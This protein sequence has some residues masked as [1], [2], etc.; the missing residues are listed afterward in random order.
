MVSTGKQRYNEGVRR[1]HGFTLIELMIVVA[2]IG[3]LASI[4]I[5]NFLSFQCKSKQ[6]EAKA[7]LG[8]IFSVEK[9]FLSDNNTY[10]TDL[11]SLGWSPDGGPL[12]IYGFGDGVE[13]PPVNT[14]PGLPAYDPTRNDTGDP[15]VQ[16]ATPTWDVTRAKD[17][18]GTLFVGANLPPTL[19]S[20][21]AFLIG[22]VA[23][24]R[25]DAGLAVDWWYID[26]RRD[27]SSPAN[28][29]FNMS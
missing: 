24:I 18:N 11:V 8:S 5:P 23:D 26:H 14:V 21:Q 15:S 20:G 22:A 2:I 17:L 7:Q 19:C 10:G 12:Y 1:S 16:G 6:G 9:I 27:L 25:P 29:C 4:A 28:D 3:L 13:V